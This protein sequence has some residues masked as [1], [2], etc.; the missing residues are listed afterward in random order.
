MFAII[1]SLEPGKLT[2]L[3]N[4]LHEKGL[5]DEKVN[6]SEIGTDTTKIKEIVKSSVLHRASIDDLK[7]FDNEQIQQLIQ[8][9]T[10]PDDF[11]E[12]E[13]QTKPLEQDESQEALVRE[14]IQILSQRNNNKEQVPIDLQPRLGYIVSKLNVKFKVSRRDIAK[15]IN[16]HRNTVNEYANQCQKTYPDLTRLWG[17]SIDNLTQRK[18]EE[19]ISKQVSDR[20]IAILKDNINIGDTIRNKFSMQAAQRGLNL[21][22]HNDLEA[23]VTK[24]VNLYFSMDMIHGMIRELEE[25]NERLLKENNSLTLQ[26]TDLRIENEQLLNYINTIGG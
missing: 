13:G 6:L 4:K 25:K 18:T 8:D 17:Q 20:A 10:N 1:D 2:E 21:Y 22:S 15:L 9:F 7:E 11:D 16:L 26:K 3:H 5:Y 23:L 14:A 19:T 24:S 12:T